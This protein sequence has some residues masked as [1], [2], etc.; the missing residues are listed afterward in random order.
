MKNICYFLCFIVGII[1]FCELFEYKPFDNCYGSD[2]A[3]IE[4]LSDDEKKVVKDFIKKINEPDPDKKR[5]LL[6][7]QDGSA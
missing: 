5:L 7:G 6:V 1:A 2:A 3:Q 4:E